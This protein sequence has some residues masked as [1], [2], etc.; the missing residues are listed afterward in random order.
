[1]ALKDCIKKLGVALSDDDKEKDD[2]MHTEES[3]MF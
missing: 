1:M 3:K 2:D